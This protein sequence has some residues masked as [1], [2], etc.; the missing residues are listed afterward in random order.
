MT[1]ITNRGGYERMLARA[2]E[3]AQEACGPDDAPSG[4]MLVQALMA[5]FRAGS[6]AA[7][8]EAT[9]IAKDRLR[10]LEERASPLTVP[11]SGRHEEVKRI[12]DALRNMF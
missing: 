5:A 12:L 10:A 11:G 9:A 3:Y 2:E 8:D 7:R 6:L 1:E 4:L